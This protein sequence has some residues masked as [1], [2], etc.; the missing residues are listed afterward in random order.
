MSRANKLFK[1]VT[2]INKV[3]NTL[4]APNWRYECVFNP[5]KYRLKEF[6]N[7][8]TEDGSNC[9]R[10]FLGIGLS[11]DIR[12]KMKD[13]LRVYYDRLDPNNKSFF[14]A[15][16]NRSFKRKRIKKISVNTNK[17]LF[18][19]SPVWNIEASSFINDQFLRRLI[20]HYSNYK[21][22][23]HIAYALE[24]GRN[25]D[26]NEIFKFIGYCI[27]AKIADVDIAKRWRIPV[28]HVEAIR[29]IFYDFAYFPTDRLAILSY[30]R[31]LVNAGVYTDIDFAYYKRV[32]ELGEVGLKA[33]TDFYNLSTV[34]KKIIEEYLGKSII[35]N[36]LNLQ[37]S[38]KNQKDAV[39]YSNVVGN[40]ANYYIKNVE[41]E[42][43]QSK[44]RNLDAGTR[45]IEGD[46]T[47]SDV[48]FTSLDKE[49]M[50]MLTEHSLHN[51]RVEYK[52]LDM[53]K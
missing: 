1:S 18:Q 25:P 35:G 11:F 4:V 34:E 42:Y 29:L 26:F 32:F 23:R 10:R 13:A 19:K 2:P 52:T 7:R 38:I 30:I 17:G 12:Y 40:L 27:F 51:D 21:F 6:A 37:F 3:G 44:I 43:F 15:I 53:L 5:A 22:D 47:N 46:L 36:A 14:L 31:Q 41:K 24:L 33:Q 28:K 48:G 16:W 49:F 20:L 8:T 39:E 45:R 9:L 50:D